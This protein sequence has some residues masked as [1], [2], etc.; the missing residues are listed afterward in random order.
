MEIFSHLGIG[1][2]AAFS[3]SALLNCL[4]GVT[5]GTFI[6]VL[7][8]VGPLATIAIL[9]P[10][11]FS[12]EPTDALIMLAGIYYGA[13]YGGSTAS[14]LLNVPG[15]ATSAVTCLDGYP[16]AQQGRAGVALFITTIASFFGS[17]VGVILVAGFAPLLAAFAL[18]F[19]AA[20][21]FSLMVLGLIAASL[22]GRGAPLRSVAMVV[23][24]LLLG[25][26]GIDVNTA[27]FRFTYGVMELADG[28]HLVIV[29]TGMFGVAEIISSLVRPPERRVASRDITW[30]S[31]LPT[32]EDMRRSWG[33]ML[34]GTSIGSLFGALPGT[35]STIAS[36]IAYA[37]EVKIAKEPER[38]GRGAVEGVSAPE[39][40]NNAAA[41]TA[42][43]PTLTLGIP[44]DAVMAV[45][46]GAL[47]IHGIIPGPRLIVE[48]PSL[49]WGL[50]V[51]F[52]IGNVMLVILNLPLI[53][54]WVRILSIPYSAL[55]PS[56]LVFICVGVYS[57][58][59]SAF[60]VLMVVIFGL[61]G[62]GLKILRFEPAPLL[63]GLV[64]GPMMEE[65]FRRALLISRGSAWV[66]VERPISAAFLLSTVALIAWITIERIRGRK[67]REAEA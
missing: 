59:N 35:G 37:T 32:R 64:L 26:V 23:V 7:P 6:G 56:I 20:E 48:Q 66:F 58:R 29:A 51:S 24:G 47:M 67:E 42:F 36:F 45:M 30:R 38:F 17:F 8:G 63:L 15:T 55:F 49:F 3:F 21:Y 11:T 18:Q 54:I 62:Y 13:Q 27:E 57:I 4:I 46:I 22:V 43:I 16:M 25:I 33:P 14:I 52:M 44:G 34:R 61:V 12:H 10:V 9:L 1:I 31:L 53:G 39:S 60:D 40:A 50:I 2:E 28:I 65:N 5:L 41:Q 19:S